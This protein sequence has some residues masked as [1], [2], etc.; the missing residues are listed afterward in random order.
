MRGFITTVFGML[1]MVLAFGCDLPPDL[2][3]DTGTDFE[4]D[5]ANE[6]D[7]DDEKDTETEEDEDL[8]DGED[9][10]YDC[11]TA[12]KCEELEGNIHEDLI[13]PGE[14]VC[15]E[16]TAYKIMWTC[17]ICEPDSLSDDD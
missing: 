14:K 11:R 7:T 5:T 8:E 12:R 9:C 15:C 10:P 16:T 13:C 17:L 2:Y 1:V 3:L 6:G 4:G